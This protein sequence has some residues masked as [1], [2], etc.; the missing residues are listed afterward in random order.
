MISGKHILVLLAGAPGTGKTYTS[1]IIKNAFQDFMYVPLDEFK[2]H[3]YDEIGFD[4]VEQ[5]EILDEKAR[6]RFYQALQIMMSWNKMIIGDYPFSYKQKPNIAKLIDEYHY[7][8]ITVRLETDFQTLFKRQQLRDENETRHLGHLMNHY[9]FGDVLTP[10][11]NLDGM[12]SFEDFRKRM[13]DR[14]YDRFVLGSLI[15]LDV[16]DYTKIDYD[17]LIKQLSDYMDGK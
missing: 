5:K 14:Q 13:K 1:K 2:E 16:T 8:V 6:Q 12:P 10:N 15:R 9:H 3:I 7:N 11:T 4:N 17:G